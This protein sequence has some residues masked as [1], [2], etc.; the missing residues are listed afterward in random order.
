MVF[1]G[2]VWSKARTTHV[3]VTLGT[4]LM[5]RPVKMLMSARI[6]PVDMGSVTMSLDLTGQKRKSCNTYC[7][8]KSVCHRNLQPVLNFYI[9]VLPIFKLF[10]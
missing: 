6:Y 3:S 2:H 1:Q 10:N 7:Q 8:D 4:S 5:D 9:E